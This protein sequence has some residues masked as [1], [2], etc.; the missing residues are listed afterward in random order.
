MKRRILIAGL[1][2]AAGTLM[3]GKII[4]KEDAEDKTNVLG[5]TKISDQAKEG[6]NAYL[7]EKVK[8]IVSKKKFKIDPEKYYVTS[9][10][11]KAIGDEPS[12]GYLGVMP[13]DAKNK[14]IGPHNVTIVK[15]TFTELAAPCRETDTVV[16]IKDGAKWK[17]G[18]LFVIA[19]D[20]KEDESDLP[21]FNLTSFGGID[22]IEKKD[23]TYELTLKKPVGKA[24][25]AGTKIRE[26]QYGNTYVYDKYGAIPIE[27]TKW[28]GKPRKGSNFRPGTV[29][30]QLILICNHNKAKDK[31]MLFDDLTIE[32]IDVPEK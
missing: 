10:W 18:N 26:Q 16:K 1:A 17:K 8:T 24:Y 12:F 30:G 2:F 22:N 3:A 13:F 20:A 32:E 4:V 27:W 23:G 19:F 28:Q 5:G 11:V 31:S 7:V 29:F 25:P 14:F 15:G 9:V 21:N 6:K